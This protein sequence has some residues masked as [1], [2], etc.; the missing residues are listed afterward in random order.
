[1]ATTSRWR[2]HRTPPSPADRPRTASSAHRISVL[3]GEAAPGTAVHRDRALDLGIA[4][5]RGCRPGGPDKLESY[6]VSREIVTT[7]KAPRSSSY[8]QAVKAAGLVF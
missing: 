1:M 5:A 8:S 6:P 4:S 2:R 7:P 3:M